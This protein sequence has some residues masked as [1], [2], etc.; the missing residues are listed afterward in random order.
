MT[1]RRAKKALLSAQGRPVAKTVE[2]TFTSAVRVRDVILHA[3]VTRT[4][5]AR[6][7]AEAVW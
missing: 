2:V 6:R 7:S 4:N 1:W 3:V 5:V